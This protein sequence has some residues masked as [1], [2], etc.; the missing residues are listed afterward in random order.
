MTLSVIHDL[1]L[2]FHLSLCDR[3]SVILRRS[4]FRVFASFCG[5]VPALCL[6]MHHARCWLGQHAAVGKAFD[7]VSL[8]M[9]LSLDWMTA[10]LDA[11]MA[12]APSGA[13]ASSKPLRCG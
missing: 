2:S 1:C 7:L 5:H 12:V 11:L 9:R 3:A 4:F 13:Q 10:L 6:E 8:F